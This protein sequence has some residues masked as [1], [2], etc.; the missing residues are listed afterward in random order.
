M[1][2][3]YYGGENFFESEKYP[4]GTGLYKI[5]SISDNTIVLDK[6]ENYRNQDEVNKNIQTIYV[7]IFSEIGEVYNSFKIGNIDIMSTSSMLY[8]NYI[9]TMGYYVKEYKGRAYDFLSYNCNDYLMKE[10]SVRQAIGYAIDKENIVS[11]VFNNKYNTS[12]YP[13]DYGSFVYTANLSNS[14]YNPEKAKE[15]LMNDGWKYTNNRWRKNGRILAVTIS[16]NSSNT[17]RCEVAKII[18]EQLQNIGIQVTVSQVSDSQYNYFLTNKNYQILLTGVYNSYSPELTYF[19]GEK[20][21]ANYNNDEVKAIIND[22]KNI[23][24]QKLLEEKYKTLIEVTKD[25]CAYISLYRNKNFLLVNQNVVG[26]F[27][28]TNFGIFENFGSWNRE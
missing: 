22:V 12:E 17:Q 27:N 5:S 6:N 25:D 4:I 23:T 18:K 3:D 14:G 21:I 28:P 19:Y 7:N 20:N 1:C 24:D 8:E 15:V 9:G 11:T 16:V 13:L 26:N 2:Q 10:K